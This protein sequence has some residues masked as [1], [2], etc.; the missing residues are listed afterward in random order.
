MMPE[1]YNYLVLLLVV[2]LSY[3]T[4]RTYQVTAKGFWIVASALVL[5]IPLVISVSHLRLQEP[6]SSGML[7]IVL[8]C[9]GA[10]MFSILR[11]IDRDGA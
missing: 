3:S 11:V 7:S 8:V 5:T 6:M 1:F 4:L 10:W 9:L 2:A